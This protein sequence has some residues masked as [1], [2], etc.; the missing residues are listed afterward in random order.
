[1]PGDSNRFNKAEYIVIRVTLLA[2]LLIHAVEFV[3]RA[4]FH[5]KH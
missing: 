3:L 2:M 4:A 1:M 5:V